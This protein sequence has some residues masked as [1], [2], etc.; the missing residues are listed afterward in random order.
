MCHWFPAR[1]S[2]FRVVTWEIELVEGTAE[3]LCVEMV[4]N[5]P[6]LQN[7]TFYVTVQNGTAL[8]KLCE[9]A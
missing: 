8:G 7:V 9:L 4:S 2:Q 6:L 3:E 5:G 1:V